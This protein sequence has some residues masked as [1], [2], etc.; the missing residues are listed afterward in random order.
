MLRHLQERL[1]TAGGVREIR[2]SRVE[3]SFPGSRFLS[4]ACQMSPLVFK[5]PASNG[6]PAGHSL[7]AD[8]VMVKTVA[9]G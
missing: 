8:E 5:L 4:F 9:A 6:H 7:R 1:E 2:P 3:Q